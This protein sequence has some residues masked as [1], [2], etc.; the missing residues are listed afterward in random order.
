M[1][2][3][4]GLKISFHPTTGF[5]ARPH[6]TYTHSHTLT[7]ILTRR[8]TQDSHTPTPHTQHSDAVHIYTHTH[9]LTHNTHTIRSLE[10]SSRP[11]LDLSP[12]PHSETLRGL[13]EF[14]GNE[15][16]LN[17]KISGLR[18]LYTPSRVYHGPSGTVPGVLCPRGPYKGRRPDTVVRPVVREVMTVLPGRRRGRSTHLW[19]PV[20]SAFTS[21]TTPVRVSRRKG[22]RGRP[23]STSRPD[24][25][26]HSFGTRWSRYPNHRSSNTRRN[27][28]FR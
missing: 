25:G 4:P 9:T 26:A 23:H 28:T 19:V 5:D 24:P 20:A 1:R 13:F 21:G 17:K 2:K 18:L 16:Q 14:R 22:R 3:N 27:S 10:D 8:L 12:R 6:H 7:D 11:L 15:F